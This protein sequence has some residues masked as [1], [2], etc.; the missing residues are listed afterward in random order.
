MS[1]SAD[2]LTAMA[3]AISTMTLYKEGH[4]ARER[5]VDQA[6][7][8]MLLLQEAHAKPD[9]TFLG[10]EIIFNRRPLRELRSWDWGTR[11]SNA[12]IQRLEIL[13]PVS[14]EELDAFLD[15]V[16]QRITQGF[17]D[18]SEI[19]Q[20][21]VTNIRYGAV[22]MRGESGG[23][24]GGERMATATLAYTLR[25]EADTVRWLHE[26]LQNERDLHM[27]EAEAIVRSLSVAMHG[28]QAF[29]IP[30][31]RLKQFDQ[32]TT[33]HALN[34]SILT[35]AL[36]EFIGLG[37]KEV[38]SFG[39]A[40]LLH[41]L[42]KV[43]IPDEILNKPGKL[44]EG[45]RQ[46]MNSHTVEGARLILAAEEHLD[47]AA[48]VAYEHHIKL[49]GG[50][51]PSFEFPRKCHQASDLV[52]VCDVFDALRTDRPYRAAW[53][54]DRI[55][56]LIR[57]GSG[58]EFDPD[59]A[60]AFVRMFS[61]WE[62]RIAELRDEDEALPLSEEEGPALSMEDLDLD[63]DEEDAVEWA[64]VVAAAAVGSHELQD[65]GP[66]AGTSME[67]IDLDEEP[68]AAVEGVGP[69]VGEGRRASVEEVDPGEEPPAAVEEVDLDLDLDDDE[70]VDWEDLLDR[71]SD[72]EEDMSW[73]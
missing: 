68:P 33:T 21:R 39:I 23:K 38:R 52:H 69:E 56:M 59:I 7:E 12:G 19:R 72:D 5:A 36:A 14:R 40:G 70:D 17:I 50:G 6:Y 42:G 28:D 62:T 66:G 20:T 54:T 58:Q 11:F 9:F 10:N 55:L 49:N 65:G 47:L 48:V 35:M 44:T 8:R 16:L 61:Q 15:E 53:D 31:L 73:E 1:S 46:V 41:D 67:E 32:Y 4:P 25:E 57:E 34:V 30:L 2:F 64:E 71:A 51:Y 45:E 22:A 13:G 60:H 37:P 26:E 43:K 24:G 27:V 3:Q 18:T 63:D 29:L